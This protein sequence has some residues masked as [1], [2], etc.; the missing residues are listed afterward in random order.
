MV[1]S[2]RHGADYLDKKVVYMTVYIHVSKK[3]KKKVTFARYKASHM[4][5]D[6]KDQKAP[7]M[8]EQI[9]LVQLITF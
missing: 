1:S 7:K 3:K 9:P 8:T 6:C 4:E 2:L 5:I